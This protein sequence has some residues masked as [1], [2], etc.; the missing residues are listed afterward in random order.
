MNSPSSPSENKP[1]SVLDKGPSETLARPWAS[2]DSFSLNDASLATGVHSE[3][4]RYY[5]RLGL[6]AARAWVAGEPSFDGL[7]LD[8]V[9]RIE[10]YRENLNLT[11][12]GLNLISEL[13]R[14]SVL[15]H[16]DIVFLNASRPRSV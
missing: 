4:L 10:N 8:E 15:H 5:C 13:R 9:A 11:R 14:D 1:Y 7:A 12:R 6:I 16:S 3:L 2:S